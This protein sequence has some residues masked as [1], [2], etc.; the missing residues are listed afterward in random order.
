MTKRGVESF[1]A[2]V[3][4]FVGSVVLL[5]SPDRAREGAR[6]PHSP[7]RRLPSPAAGLWL[8]HISLEFMK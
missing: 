3:I 5:P 8:D 6:A 1:V 7:S 4:C 2:F